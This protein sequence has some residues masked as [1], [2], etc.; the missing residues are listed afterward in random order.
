MINWQK[1]HPS[2]KVKI[3]LGKLLVVVLGVQTKT[4]TCMTEHENVHREE[5]GT[6]LP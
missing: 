6:Q 4:K 1:T 2:R 3:W 5:S